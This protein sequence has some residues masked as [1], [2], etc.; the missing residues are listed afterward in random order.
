[1]VKVTFKNCGIGTYGVP[2]CF[3]FERKTSSSMKVFDI[4]KMMVCILTWNFIMH[5]SNR[6]YQIIMC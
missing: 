6:V 4:I 3:T 2:V 5:M 1:V